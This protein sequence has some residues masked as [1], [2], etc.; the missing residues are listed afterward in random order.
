MQGVIFDQQQ[1]TS[2]EPLFKIFSGVV[3]LSSA[4]FISLFAYKNYDNDNLNLL[5]I[6][7]FIIL[8]IQFIFGIVGITIKKN[9]KQYIIL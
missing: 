7:F 6:Y 1:P 9:Q 5:V 2:T 8:S 4:L 3:S